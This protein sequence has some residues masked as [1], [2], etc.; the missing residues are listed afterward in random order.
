M[1]NNSENN[2]ASKLTPIGLTGSGTYRNTL[3]EQHDGSRKF[4]YTY[5]Q[6]LF[7]I[8]GR[9]CTTGIPAYSD[10]SGSHDPDGCVGVATQGTVRKEV[11]ARLNACRSVQ[12]LE[13]KT[14]TGVP[15]I[16]NLFF[17]SQEEIAELERLL[18]GD[19]YLLLMEAIGIDS[20][21]RDAFKTQ[22]LK[23]LYNKANS[24]Y[25]G[26][27]SVL[28]EDG[29]W[30][31]EWLYEPV[32]KSMRVLLPSIVLFLDLCKRNPMTL[33]R[34]GG[35]HK[36]TSHAMQRIE[37]QIMLETCANLWKKYPKMFL[38]TVHDCIKCSPRDAP[39]VEAELKRTF[40]KYHVSAKVDVKL[41]EKPSDANG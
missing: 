13:Y 11:T 33:K 34:K 24:R 36:Y 39:K 17:P 32:R 12:N 41:H 4:N 15:L 2:C 31:Y 22:F 30:G 1:C 23:F 6:V 21:E 25:I 14:A 19:I 40:E 18:Q 16:R 29:T 5:E 37:S 8:L 35:F 3:P 27:Q 20:E 9:S 7:D 38:V 10:I 28:R 26:K